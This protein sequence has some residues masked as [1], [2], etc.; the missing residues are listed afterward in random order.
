MVVDWNIINEDLCNNFPLWKNK[1]KK[2]S[3]WKDQIL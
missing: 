2:S 1:E 3:G